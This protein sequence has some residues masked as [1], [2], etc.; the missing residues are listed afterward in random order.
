MSL[1]TELGLGPN[2]IVLDGDPAP[3]PEKIGGTTPNFWPMSVVAKRLDGPIR[4]HLV[5]R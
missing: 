5:G 3:P 1:G 2:H 4:C